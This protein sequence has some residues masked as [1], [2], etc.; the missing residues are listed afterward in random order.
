M[1]DKL[2]REATLIDREVLGLA[3]NHRT[4]NHVLEL[5]DVA[6]PRVRFQQFQR[7]LTAIAYVLSG[8]TCVVLKEMF[9]QQ[10]NVF[11][12]FA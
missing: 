7:V 9:D 1:L 3:N 10:G 2:L 5:A 4:L 6:G 12:A 11:F 8:P